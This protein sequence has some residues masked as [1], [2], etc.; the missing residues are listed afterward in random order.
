MAEKE[1]EKQDHVDE[2]NAEEKEKDK[3]SAGAGIKFKVKVKGKEQ[4]V[5]TLEK[6]TVF[7]NESSDEENEDGEKGYC[8]SPKFRTP[9]MFA[10]INLKFK[11]RGQTVEYFVKNTNGIANSEDPEQEQSDLGLHCLP[12]P[13]CPKT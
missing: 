7:E 13:I 10:V 6:K 12:R 8:K 2:E 4:E 5:V 3:S 1:K 9:K 11:Q